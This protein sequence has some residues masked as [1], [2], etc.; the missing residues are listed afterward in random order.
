MFKRLEHLFHKE[1]LRELGP[2]SLE[3]RRFSR[4]LINVY[5]YLQGECK[6]DRA[7]LFSVAPSSR[8][9]GNGHKLKRGRFP[10]NVRKHFFTV[11]V[12]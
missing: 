8:T 3:K 9:R 1:K 12:T 2:F 4:D 6:E 10:L 7:R 11:R 5:K